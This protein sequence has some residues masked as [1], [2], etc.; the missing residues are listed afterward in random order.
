MSKLLYKPLKAFTL[1]ALLVLAL[2]IPAYFFI[3]DYIWL[4]ELDE[5]NEI[6]RERVE[7]GLNKLNL[8]EHELTQ[9]IFLLNRIQPGIN[10]RPAKPSDI[11]RDS[12][13]ALMRQNPTEQAEDID[14]FRVLSTYIN[15]QGK[16]YHLLVETNVEE[17]E[18]T[19][20]AIALITLL[21]FLLLVAGFLLINKKISVQIWRPFRMSLDQLQAFDLNS[22][23]SIQFEKTDIEEFNELHSTLQ[24]LIEKNISVFRAQKEFTENASHELQTPLAIIKSKLDILL[25]HPSLTEEQYELVESL[26][27][28]LSRVSRINKNLLLLAKIENHQFS[29]NEEVDI[30]GLLSQSI[31]FLTEHIAVKHITLETQIQPNVLLTTNKS[32]FEILLTNLLLNA[33][34][35]N[36]ERGKITV[37]LFTQK[38]T[39]SNTGRQALKGDAIFKR[40]G[41]AALHTP[42]SGLGLSIVKEICTH[43]KWNIDYDFQNGWHVFSI[44]F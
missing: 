8:S 13:Y 34:R 5:N 19:M 4:T 27:M 12:T 35:H 28:P 17:T 3:V 42:N 15:I 21:F 32:L 38:L 24:K 37:E 40:F 14:R 44:R 25:Q 9:A 7:K 6:V 41:S 11:K 33:I 30:S 16:P 22:H 23:N 1:Y 26:N 39:I 18:E 36:W 31:D 2:S 20:A 10:L 43:Y 29:E